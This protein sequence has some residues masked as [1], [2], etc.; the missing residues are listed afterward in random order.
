[1]SLQIP[2]K[3]ATQISLPLAGILSLPP[4]S[5]GYTSDRILHAGQTNTSFFQQ[6]ILIPEIG[7]IPSFTSEYQYNYSLPLLSTLNLDEIQQTKEIFLEAQQQAAYSH[8]ISTVHA[9]T[10]SSFS[11]LSWLFGGI[12]TFTWIIIIIV[13]Y[14]C[15]KYFHK[16]KPIVTSPS[17]FVMEHFVPL[18]SNST[19]A[20]APDHENDQPRQLSLG[21]PQRV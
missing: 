13:I 10:E 4:G 20:P 18:L 16:I 2:G 21:L 12:S 7:L 15:W 17:T 6:E 1:M 8:G 19:T 14:F 9:S 3:E 5:T 11:I